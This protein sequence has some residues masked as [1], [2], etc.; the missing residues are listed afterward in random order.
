[1][2]NQELFERLVSLKTDTHT[3]YYSDDYSAVKRDKE[4]YDNALASQSVFTDEEISAETTK[5]WNEM[6]ARIDKATGY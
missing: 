5:R 3:A 4:R 2:K 6:I 1:M